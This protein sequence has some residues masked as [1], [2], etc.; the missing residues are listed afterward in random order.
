MSPSQLTLMDSQLNQAIS[1]SFQT[2]LAEQ[3]S[4]PVA[5]R[6]PWPADPPIHML[7]GL[8]HTPTFH[9][10]ATRDLWLSKKPANRDFWVIHP[11]IGNLALHNPQPLPL[12]DSQLTQ[13]SVRHLS[14]TLSNPHTIHQ[15]HIAKPSFYSLATR[16]RWLTQP[17]SIVC[18]G[19]LAN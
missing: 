6:D 13:T 1:T 4:Y 17:L 8:L 16:Y 19:L 12:R 11:L 10:P 2:L 14:Q 15:A 18:K 3:A 9:P 5:T 7:Q